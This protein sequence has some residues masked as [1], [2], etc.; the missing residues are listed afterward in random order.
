VK[1]KTLQFCVIELKWN[2]RH[3]YQKVS[4]KLKMI[5]L[6]AKYR[7]ANWLIVK[8]NIIVIKPIIYAVSVSDNT[9]AYVTRTSILIMPRIHRKYDGLS[10]GTVSCNV[11]GTILRFSQVL[12]K[13][14]RFLF[15]F[16]IWIWYVKVFVTW[17]F[18]DSVW[19]CCFSS[20]NVLCD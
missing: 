9:T 20:F 18:I 7:H 3:S 1:I 8:Q 5:G 15:S 16:L 13:I 10:N 11:I 19:F 17:F 2:P 12:L 4:Q 6:L 14:L